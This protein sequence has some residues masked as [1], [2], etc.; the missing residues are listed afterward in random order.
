VKCDYSKSFKKLSYFTTKI[1][2]K[3]S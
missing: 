3:A 2:A 1:Y